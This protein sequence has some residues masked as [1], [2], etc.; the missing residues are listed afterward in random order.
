[1]ENSPTAAAETERNAI[2]PGREL[3]SFR[4]V[5]AGGGFAGVYAARA[6]ARVLGR[7]RARQE[8][9]LISERNA[10]VFQP[11]LPEV[12]GSEL[13][14]RHVVTPV[15]QLCGDVTVLRARIADVDL[16]GHRL[17]L[18]AGPFTGTREVR[19]EHLA[20]AVGSVVD[21][22]RV[23]G[24][25]EHAY[26]IN[27]VG[28][29][30]ALRGAVIDRF[31]E[32]ALAGEPERVRRLLTFVVVGG[33]YSG[34]E[35]VGQ[36]ADLAH[37]VAPLYPH[38]GREQVRVV[39]VH[40]GKHLMPEIAERLG[41]YAERE[42]RK[43]GV[44]IILEARVSAVT[45]SKVF[46]LDGRV[47]ETHTVVSTVGNAPNPLVT[48]LCEANGLAAT[49][50]R[51]VTEPTLQVPGQPGLWVAGDCGAIPL[52]D[53]QLSPPTGQFAMRQGKRL[54][55]NLAA[56]LAG[57]APEPF[58]Y[59][60]VGELANIGRRSA[61]ADV[62]GFRFSGF[63]AWW[64]WRTVYLSKLPGLER[65]L[66]VVIDWTLDLFF[67]RDIS[68]LNP[69]MSKVVKEMH[70]EPGDSLFRAG[71]PAFSFYILRSGKIEYRTREGEV[72]RTLEPGDHFGEKALQGKRTWHYNAMATEPTEVVSIDAELFEQFKASRSFRN[73]VEGG[74]EEP[75]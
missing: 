25:A 7:T 40:S 35:T 62:F 9:A 61:V 65:K 5:I 53:G 1:M 18:N 44:E 3:L 47:I 50:G 21:L 46:L 60:G 36:I 14:P 67:P 51:I 58:V 27:T 19:F 38:A 11:M 34:V 28:D 74:A 30:M 6:L 55:K 43:R 39:L 16:P 57:K 72:V 63:F 45:A 10:M 69:K 37:D 68:L 17:T 66:R 2:P 70:L 22:R 75:L 4:V 33:G 41:H 20:I 32:A 12:C 8:V 71:E 26:L 29:A 52:P 49:K 73:A 13:S 59:K 31:E 24:M 42:L 15:R 23:P 54:G 48:R 64:L 56:V